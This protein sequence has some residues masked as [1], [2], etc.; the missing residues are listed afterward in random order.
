MATYRPKY[1]IVDWVVKAVYH[2]AHLAN[3][4]LSSVAVREGLAG[5][6]PSSWTE[7][8]QLM[9][10]SYLRLVITLEM[11]IGQGKLPEESDFPPTLRGSAQISFS[12]PDVGRFLQIGAPAQREEAQ[13]EKEEQGRVTDVTEQGQLSNMAYDFGVAA[14]TG[15]M[16]DDM[17]FYTPQPGPEVP[18]QTPQPA[19]GGVELD[20]PHTGYGGM[21]FEAPPGQEREFSGS[22]SQPEDASATGAADLGAIF[23][24]DFQGGDD[25]DEWA[26]RVLGVES[27]PF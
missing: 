22:V 1:Y 24:D 27:I 11:S 15:F 2:I 5:L 7:L 8:L 14:A 18:F 4:V 23:G 3:Q 10:T 13:E 21:P 26:N 12:V 19:Q 25:F 20:P 17:P 9:P 6:S 16:G